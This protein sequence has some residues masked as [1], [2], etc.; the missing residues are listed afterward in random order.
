MKRLLVIDA[1]NMFVRAYIVN[2]SMST[3]GNPVGGVLGFLG[4]L[5]KLIR[6][7]KP[8]QVIICWDGPG[9]SLKRRQ[10]VKE[11]KEGRK[12]LRKNYEVDGMDEQ[13]EVDN[14][15]WQQFLLAA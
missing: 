7:S 10:V 15:I 6:E 5:R 1:L 14:K 4:I 12:P 8:D 11:Y 2:P 3:N 13:S 9:G